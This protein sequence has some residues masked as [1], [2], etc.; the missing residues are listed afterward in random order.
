M[1]A[2]RNLIQIWLTALLVAFTG[3]AQANLP[4]KTSFIFDGTNRVT[5]AWVAYPGMVYALNTTTNL[6]QPWQPAPGQP[7]TF[8]TS[9]N[10]LIFSFP[11][12]AAACFFQVVRLDTQGPKVSRTSPLN[13]SVGVSQ[14]AVLQAWLTDE[15]G[16]NPNSII[17]AIGT[18]SPV[19]LS[20]RRLTWSTN[21][22]LTY[23]PATNEVL[24]ALGQTVNV[25]L[26][27][28]DVL[29]SVLKIQNA[30]IFLG[31]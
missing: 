23:T 29:E 6:L 8:T 20:D 2:K 19:T 1:K 14:Q 15:T 5:L 10:S 27:A 24:G 13:N 3:N 11:V 30:P 4:I 9:N 31:I 18:N 26:S 22:V 21:G 17:F 16:V 12:N 25:S 7:A 28:A